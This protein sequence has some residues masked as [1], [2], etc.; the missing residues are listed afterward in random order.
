MPKIKSSRLCTML[1]CTK[2]HA[3]KGYCSVHYMRWHKYD[4]PYYTKRIPLPKGY[5]FGTTCLLQ[6]ENNVLAKGLCPI[7]YARVHRLKMKN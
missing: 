4:D 6:C 5:W 2:K 3:A 1:G 7:H